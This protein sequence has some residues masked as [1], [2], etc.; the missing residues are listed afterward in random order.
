MSRINKLLFSLFFIVVVGCGEQA[1]TQAEAVQGAAAPAVSQ[2]AKPSGLTALASSQY[3]EGV[4]YERIAKPVPTVDKAKIE[5]TEVFWYGCSHCYDFEAHLSVW[6][7]DLAD[8]VVFVKNPAMWDRQG[9]MEKHARIYYTA[10]I[11]G[12]LDKV[13][14]A[15]FRALNVDRNPLR[16]DKEI[17][18]LFT[19]NGVAKED[20]ERTFNS[21]GVTSS[22]RQAEARQRS[23]RVQGTPEMIVDGTYRVTAGMAGGH[24][25]MLKVVNFLVAKVRKDKFGP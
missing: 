24:E 20:F 14:S 3:E 5:V 8:D 17:A 15:A 25:G 1:E 2:G 12:V 16:D 4:H 18:K 21:F 23:Y 7:A 6:T 9:I 22:V 13:G 19:D 11:L 10:K